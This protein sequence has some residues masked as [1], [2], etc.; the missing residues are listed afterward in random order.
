[1]RLLLLTIDYPPETGGVQRLLSGMVEH[2]SGRHQVRVAVGRGLGTASPVGP[3][4]RRFVRLAAL[5]LRALQSWRRH[6]PELVI[7]GHALLAPM[8][9]VIGS[10][11]RTKYVAMA[12][13]S[14]VRSP[15]TMRLVR[16]GLRGASRIVAISAFTRQAVL[17]GGLSP[18]RVEVILPAA[19]LPVG[20]D[21]TGS[22]GD[23]EP[24]LLLCVARLAE[25]YKGHDVLIKAMPLVRAR[26]PHARLVIVGEG[27][28]RPYLERLAGSLTVS[29][30]VTFT[31]ELPDEELEAWYRRCALF[32]LP[33]RETRDGGAEGFGLV[34]AEASL[35]GKCVVA[36][37][38][39][40]VPDAVVEGRT[41]V[42]V[43]PGD[44][45]AVADALIHLLNHPDQAVDMG[46]EGS[47]RGRQ[48]LS[49]TS[50]ISRLEPLFAAAGSRN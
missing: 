13:G 12:Y 18:E 15:K 28:L 29:D 46:Q 17:A 4:W 25:R 42:L 39:G 38:S 48:E 26:A 8:C 11:T 45:G 40:G 31:G 23:V 3:R 33:S 16:W 6:R 35:R 1:M 30:A 7:C 44:V 19:A 50:F 49:W 2:L 24:G 36:G 41:G 20:N 32:V 37:R 43:D 10:L 22:H 27:P 34:F 47:R 21:P 5:T 9:R 14:E